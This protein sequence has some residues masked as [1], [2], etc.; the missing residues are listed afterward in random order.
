M[1]ELIINYDKAKSLA[2]GEILDAIALCPFGAIEEHGG[3]IEIN[4]GCKMCNECVRKGPEGVFELVETDVR[5]PRIDKSRWN[6][7]AVYIEHLEGQVHPVSLELVG[8]AR[9]LAGKVN[10]PVYALLMGHEIKEL[11]EELLHYGVDEVFLYDYTELRGFL[12]E[13]Y[14]NVF[15]DFVDKIK[16]STILVGA[17]TTGRSLAPRAAARIRTGLTA[18]CTKLDIKDNTDLV[19]IRPAFGGN[20]MAQICTPDHRPQIATVRYKIFDAPVRQAVGG[21]KVTCCAIDQEKLQSRIKPVA[22]IGKEKKKTISEAEVIVAAG[23]GIRTEK[24]LSM[25]YE[26]AELLGA[27]IATTRPLIEA[28]WISSKRQIGLSGRTVKPKLIITLGVSGSVQFK[29]GMENSDMI[30]SINTDDNANI[31]DVCHYAVKGDVYDVVPK[32]LCRIKGEVT[33][34]V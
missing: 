11:A 24:D 31:F 34:H 5:R 30:I 15:A 8:K 7:I 33:G 26:L 20:V 18:D 14:T 27:E 23:R 32:L 12:I 4:A 29:A 3:R 22:V 13:P 1:P 2:P 28:G 6:G 21:G 9:E 10:F 17:T 19:Q 16:P 25:A